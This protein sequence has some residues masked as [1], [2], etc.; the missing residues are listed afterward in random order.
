MFH[1]ISSPELL[2]PLSIRRPAKSSYQDLPEEKD[3]KLKICYLFWKN[4]MLA[5]ALK[6]N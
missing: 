5:R 1:L 6:G 4:V 2:S 3:K